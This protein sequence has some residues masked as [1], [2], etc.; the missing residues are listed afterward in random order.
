MSDIVAFRQRIMDTIEANVPGIAKVDWY[1][2]LFDEDDVREW[3][4]N[5]P[6]V[7]VAVLTVPNDH[8]TT[9]EILADLHCLATVITQDVAEPRDN[10]LQNWTLM[11]AIAKLANLNQFGDP[12]AA[13]ACDVEMKR[14]RH[15]EL[16][17]EGVAIGIVEWRSNLTIG[18]NRQAE[19]DTFP[20]AG[21]MPDRVTARAWLDDAP[22]E[23]WSDWSGRPDEPPTDVT[24]IEEDAP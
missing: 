21:A 13:A 19:R 1:D 5:T 3:G 22:P 24:P 18:R 7:M 12:N 8:H 16:R 2:G 6:A 17:R 23:S 14:L 9:G 15:P 20:G 4:L 11:E 10:D